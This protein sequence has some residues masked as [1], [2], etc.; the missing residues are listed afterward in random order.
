[1]RYCYISDM[2]ML[3]VMTQLSGVLWTARKTPSSQ[4]QVLLLL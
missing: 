2:S 1:M 3:H 4:D